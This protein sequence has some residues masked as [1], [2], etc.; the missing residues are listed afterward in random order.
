MTSSTQ[1]DDHKCPHCG[2]AVD[3]LRAPAVSVIEGR[4]THF[5]S[6]SCRES[7]LHRTIEPPEPQAETPLSEETTPTSTTEETLEDVPSKD[8]FTPSP[9]R[10]R[11]SPLLRNQLVATALLSLLLLAAIFVPPF[12]GGMFPVVLI[13]AEAFLLIVYGTFRERRRGAGRIAEVAATPLAAATILACAMLEIE[14]RLAAIS[15]AAL[16]LAREAGRGLEMIGRKRSGVLP[17]VDGSDSDMVSSSWRDNS[18]TAAKIRRIALFLEWARFPAAGMI[19][20]LVF[21]TYSRSATEGLLAGATALV[22]LG[23][24]ALRMV[25]G[26]A[27]LATALAAAKRNV[28]FRDAHIVDQV[29]SARIAL[30]MARRS[31]VEEKVEVVDWKTAA[32]ADEKA[33]F[34]ALGAI[35]HPLNGRIATAISDFI[36]TRGVSPVPI[37]DAALIPGRGVTGTTSKGRT[38]CGSRLSLLDEGVSTGLLEDHARTIEA[39]GRRAIFAALDGVAC[40]AFGIEEAPV[41]GAEDAIQR[42]K[43]LGVEPMIVTSAEVSAAQALASRLG[44]ET[45]RFETAEDQVGEILGQLDAAGDSAILIGHG[46]AFEDNLR[47]AAAAVAIGGGASTQ[48]GVDARDRHI[49]TVPWLVD[50]AKRAHRSVEIN[51]VTTGTAAAIGLGLSSGW[52]SPPVVVVAA[53]LCFAAAAFSTFNG[54]YPLIARSIQVVNTALRTL[55]Q[56]VARRGAGSR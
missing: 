18:K 9:M 6:P 5:C 28:H 17:I 15:A 33:V 3:P 12:L 11:R 53:G 48:A 51:L 4:I 37:D 56:V 30:F 19:G 44:V 13:G 16:L 34:S 43:H 31:L 39:S 21:L 26:D 14:P 54:P 29:S 22:A 52:F 47:A 32:K 49:Q 46:G 45:V 40:A 35:E 8:S 7:H 36:R 2:K 50:S 10:E 55:R 42:L 25:T 27:H 38:L 23:P 24:R 41:S 1:N 20:F